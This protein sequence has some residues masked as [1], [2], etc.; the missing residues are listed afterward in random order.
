MLTDPT[1]LY[2]S[3]QIIQVLS[4]SHKNTFGVNIC[5]APAEELPEGTVLLPQC[6]GSFC[7]NA[8]IDSELYTFITR[9]ALEAFLSL[10]FEL[11]GNG[12]FLV[13]LLFRDL[14]VFAF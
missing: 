4:Y 1:V 14:P 9:Y 11:S 8:A 12:Q 13:S 7:L 5:L 2:S 10:P 3:M 6:K